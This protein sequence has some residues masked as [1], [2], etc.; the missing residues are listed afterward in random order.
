LRV[1]TIQPFEVWERLQ[2]SGLLYADGRHIPPELRF[3]YQWMRD[4]M[5]K[6]IAGYS[7]RYPWWGWAH[8]KP[9]LRCAGHLPRGTRGVRLELELHDQEVLLSDFDAW[10]FV[11]NQGYLALN[12]AEFEDFYRRFDAV[13]ADPH[14]WPPPKSWHTAIVASWGRIFDLDALATNP[15]WSGPEGYIQATFECLR[16]EDVRHVT[17]FVAR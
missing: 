9:D 11:L 5:V 2:M 16:L 7:G 14:A 13:V 15:D 3:A 6:R 12:E 10:H 8:P 17:Y 1:W 4:Q